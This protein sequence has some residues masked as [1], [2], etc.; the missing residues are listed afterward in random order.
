MSSKP[1]IEIVSD[2][3]CPWCFVGKRNLEAAIA[4]NSKSVDDF[5]ITWRPFLLRPNA[6]E[7][8]LP[9]DPNPDERVPFRLK[10]A[11][12][13]AGINFSGKTDRTPNTLKGHALLKFAKEQEA[14]GSSGLQHKV[15]EILFR[16]YFTDGVFV[17]DG[18]EL[19]KAAEEAGLDGEASRAFF[20]NEE[21]LGQISQEALSNARRGITGVPTFFFNGRRAFSGAQ[22]V[23]RFD[24]I[25]NAPD[26]GFEQENSTK[27][28]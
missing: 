27:V 11:G 13:V 6:P 28:E 23:E 25:L 26:F 9:K 15:A 1:K 18:E 22:P 20:T 12:E 4:K 24:F 7:E 19:V 17:G 16:K 2:I 8:G 21:N 3:M 10:Q 14:N 5:D